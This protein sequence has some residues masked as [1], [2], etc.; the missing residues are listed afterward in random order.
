MDAGDAEDAEDAFVASASSTWVGGQFQANSHWSL[1]DDAS[2]VSV[3]SAWVASS[4]VSWVDERQGGDSLSPLLV[5]LV[6]C[7]EAIV[8]CRDLWK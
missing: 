7:L 3:F 2:A 6:L 4:W 1:E 5:L 8:Q